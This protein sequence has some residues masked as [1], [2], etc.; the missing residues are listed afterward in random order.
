M[1]VVHHGQKG[2]SIVTP[3]Q[4]RSLNRY[5]YHP[6]NQRMCSECL[7]VYDGIEEH[8]HHKQNRGNDAWSYEPRCKPCHRTWNAKRKSAYRADPEAMIRQRITAFKHRAEAQ[9]VQFDLDADYLIQQWVTQ[10]GLCFYTE[11]KIDFELISSSQKTA[12]PQQPSLD[13]MDP[14]KGYIKGNVV[15]C[16]HRINTMKGNFTY[17]E[18]IQMCSHITD[19]R[20]RYDE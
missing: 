15:W 2:T 19:V 7:V 16:S 5:T 20:R 17:D 3:L 11:T 18:F 4:V 8:F 12:H 9:G 13:R 6:K 1:L 10:N 14:N